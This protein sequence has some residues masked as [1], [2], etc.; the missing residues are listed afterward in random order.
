MPAAGMNAA[1]KIR[2]SGRR[3]VRLAAWKK[4]ISFHV[5]RQCDALLA[6]DKI[7]LFRKPLPECPRNTMRDVQCPSLGSIATDGYGPGVAR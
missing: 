2:K 6:S 5:R 7:S 4:P 1:V 3:R